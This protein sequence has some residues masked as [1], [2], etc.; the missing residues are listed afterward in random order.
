MPKRWFDLRS[1]YSIPITES[2]LP[3]KIEVLLRAGRH[4]LQLGDVDVEHVAQAEVDPL[5]GMKLMLAVATALG[6]SPGS[7]S[8]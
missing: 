6:V 8:G 1:R 3:T 7:W 4:P 2:N 5:R